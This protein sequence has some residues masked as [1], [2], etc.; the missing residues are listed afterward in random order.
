MKRKHSIIV[1]V[2]ILIFIALLFTGL[3]I[4]SK[5]STKNP[6][7]KNGKVLGGFAEI[8]TKQV[9]APTEIIPT[10]TDIPPTPTPT[11]IEYRVNFIDNT[12]ELLEGGNATFTW[13]IDG[14]AK[15]FHKS[16]V[17]FGLVS[18]NGILKKD[19]AP[20]DTTYTDS[21]KDFQTGDFI[22]PL[23]FVGNTIITKPGKYFTRAY[24]LIDSNN[25]W[26]DER[27]ITVKPIPTPAFDIKII[28]YPKTVKLNENSAFTWDI[29]GPLAT[30]VFTAIVGSKESKSGQIDESVDLS[31][32]PYKILT[33]EFTNGIY[34]IPLRYIGNTIMPEFGTYYIRALVLINGRNIWSDEYTLNVQ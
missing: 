17:Y 27:E 32:T 8:S 26:S 30:S 10:P 13:Y 7:I 29:S 6:V 20:A 23:R 2:L 28:N 15:L 25:F 31:K 33:K 16:A 11:P 1:F 4:K 12:K 5:S 3:F 14:P 21:V 24:A 22:I 19:T 18:N 34:S 9:P